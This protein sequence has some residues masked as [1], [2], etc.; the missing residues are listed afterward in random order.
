MNITDVLAAL[1]E[2]FKEHS[3]T[4]DDGYSD[5]IEKLKAFIRTQIEELID[6]LPSREDKNSEAYDIGATYWSEVIN[7]WKE[8]AK[9]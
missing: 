6:S 3:F 1:N 7:K 5:D 2:E 4:D 9:K 8:E